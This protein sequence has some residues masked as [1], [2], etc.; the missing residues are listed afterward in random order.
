MNS[1]CVGD[2]WFVLARVC[3]CWVVLLLVLGRVGSCLLVS[4]RVGPCLVVLAG[5][6]ARVLNY[7]RP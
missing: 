7:N 4:D 3:L 1:P 6:V 5:V 2:F